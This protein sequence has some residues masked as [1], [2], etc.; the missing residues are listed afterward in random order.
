MVRNYYMSIVLTN[1]YT[2]NKKIA[3]KKL[4][5]VCKSHLYGYYFFLKWAS[6]LIWMTNLVNVAAFLFPFLGEYVVRVVDSFFKFLLTFFLLTLCAPLFFIFLINIGFIVRQYFVRLQSACG[7]KSH[8]QSKVVFRHLL[9]EQ[10]KV[11][12]NM[13]KMKNIMVISCLIIYC[14]SISQ[15]HNC[16]Q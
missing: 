2:C 3:N 1:F 8:I 16:S 15:V 10:R 13:T 9:H 4:Y 11:T 12:G 14:C 5:F 6:K 7:D